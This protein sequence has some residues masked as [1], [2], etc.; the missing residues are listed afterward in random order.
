MKKLI[1]LIIQ[2]AIYS[3]LFIFD[4]IMAVY[5]L[6]NDNSIAVVG[7]VVGAVAFLAATII[8]IILLCTYKS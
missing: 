4:S 7:F 5:S 6:H 2:I 3:L 1:M 8:S